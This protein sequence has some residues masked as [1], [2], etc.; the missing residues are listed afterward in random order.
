MSWSESRVWLTAP[1][2]L[3]QSVALACLI[4][5][6]SIKAGNVHPLAS[7]VDMDFSDFLVSGLGLAPVF[8]RTDACSVGQLVLEGVEATARQL[9][10]NTNLGTLLLLAPLAKAL[11]RWQRTRSTRPTPAELRSCVCQVLEELDA[12]DAEWVYQAIRRAKPGGLGRVREHDIQDAPPSDLR[13]AM[14]LAAGIDAVARQYTTGFADVCGPLVTWLASGLASGLDLLT[15]TSEV[16]LRSLAEHTDGLI[17]RKAGGEVAGEVQRLARMA[18]DEWLLSRERGP[19]WHALDAFLRADGHRRN[20]GTTADLIAATLL[21][22]LVCDACSA[23]N[24][25]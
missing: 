18:L 16:Q 3:G 23:S 24:P 5:A 8:D 21:V 2:S 4:E 1:R 10:V 13:A 14:A 19:Q 9:T 17:V 20:P 7:F 6:S 22:L 11:R 15:A 25:M 12:A